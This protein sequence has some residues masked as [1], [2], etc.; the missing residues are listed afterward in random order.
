MAIGRCKN[1][2]RYGMFIETDHAVYPNQPLEI[3]IIRGQRKESKSQ[4]VKCYVVHISGNGFGIELSEEHLNIFCAIASM[5]PENMD[6]I[7]ARA[8]TAQAS[9]F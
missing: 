7:S 1:S 3:E 2:S 4:R 5:R 8:P 6:D 9:R